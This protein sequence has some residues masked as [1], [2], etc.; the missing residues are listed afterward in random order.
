M[1]GEQGKLLLERLRPTFYSSIITFPE[2]TFQFFLLATHQTSISRLNEHSE[3][4]RAPH[5]NGPRDMPR[6]GALSLLQKPLHYREVHLN[7]CLA[8]VFLGLGS[9]VVRARVLVQEVLDHGAQAVAR[10][11]ARSAPQILD[12][13]TQKFQ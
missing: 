3:Q 7:L 5:T 4:A 6:C 10:G 13:G 2:L 8:F 9:V 1:L 11:A 12:R